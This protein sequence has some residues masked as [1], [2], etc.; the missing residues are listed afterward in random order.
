MKV[1]DYFEFIEECSGMVN[2][3]GFETFDEL[4]H[5]SLNK[6]ALVNLVL[7]F[8]SIVAKSDITLDELANPFD[9]ENDLKEDTPPLKLVH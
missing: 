7:E 2:D 1:I 3:E 9:Y 8:T 5:V 4:L 6:K